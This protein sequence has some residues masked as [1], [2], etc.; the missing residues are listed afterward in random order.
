MTSADS[1]VPVYVSELS[2]NAV[3]SEHRPIQLSPSALQHVNLLVDELLTSIISSAASFNPKDIRLVG[4][5]AVFGGAGE[6]HA[7][8]QSTGPRALARA[9]VNEAEVELRSW[10]AGHPAPRGGRWPP[11]G[12]GRGLTLSKERS[13]AAFPMK[14]ALEYVRIHG[15]RFCTLAPDERPTEGDEDRVIRAHLIEHILAQ[16]GTVVQRDSSVSVATDQHLYTALCEDESVWGLFKRMK[17]KTTLEAAN[18]SAARQKK[19]PSGRSMNDL[20]SS[21]GRQSPSSAGE[22]KTSLVGAPREGSIDAGS[23]RRGAPP[24]S[25]FDA[26]RTSTEHGRFGGISGGPLRKA[27]SLSKKGIFGSPATGNGHERSNSVLSVNTRSMLGAYNEQVD[28]ESRPARSSREQEDDFDALLRSS[29]TMK[30]SLTPSRLKTFEATTRRGTNSPTS[31][32]FPHREASETSPQDELPPLLPGSN[33]P[34]TP[35]RNGSAR[36][37]RASPS[38]RLLAR[39]ASTIIAEQSDEDGPPGARSGKKESL[40]DILASDGPSEGNQRERAG[41]GSRRTVPAVV[42][43]TPPPPAPAP[44]PADR[45]APPRDSPPTLNRPQGRQAAAAVGDDDDFGPTRRRR[46]KSSAQ[47]LADFLNSTPP[48]P[49]PPSRPPASV[50]SEDTVATTKSKGLKGFM[51]KV[52]AG[53]SK[54]SSSS[55]KRKPAPLMEIPTADRDLV[56]AKRKQSLASSSSNPSSSLYRTSLEA[57]PVPNKAVQ[58]KSVLHKEPPETRKGTATP[59]S[60]AAA[61]AASATAAAATTAAV[62]IDRPTNGRL[63]TVEASASPPNKPAKSPGRGLP[64][65]LIKTQDEYVRPEAEVSGVHSV[66]ETIAAA[67]QDRQVRSLE[68]AIHSVPETAGA[69]NLA[70]AAASVSRHDVMPSDSASFQTADEDLSASTGD[71]SRVREAQSDAGVA[72]SEPT[73]QA[74]IRSAVGADVDELESETAPELDQALPVATESLVPSIPLEE[75]LPLRHLLEHATSARECQLLLGAVLTQWGVPLSYPVSISQPTPEDRVA[76]WLLAGR[77]GPVVSPS[78]STFSKAETDVMTPTETPTGTLKGVARMQYGNGHEAQDQDRDRE[79]EF[80]DEDEDDREEVLDE[81]GVEHVNKVAQV[82]PNMM[83]R[84]GAVD[85]PN[86]RDGVVQA[87]I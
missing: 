65:E 25:S 66:P 19:P 86:G 46:G 29:E 28:D 70:V 61:Y 3:I 26:S 84:E 6:K 50:A 57:P 5:P 24:P 9:A 14:E 20:K 60:A 13:G 10:Y 81:V 7:A 79:D 43:G 52:T 34:S 17:L 71:V 37:N 42:L 23:P 68:P 22:S 53:T 21:G 58:S 67:A 16:L 51:S 11:D 47:E 82:A 2:A 54:S 48:P 45:R 69:Q 75:L 83:G 30:V 63:S 39:G 4:V 64:T 62:V 41:S 44:A 77:E 73:V 76:A 40:M 80:E 74:A 33:L 18:E 12:E 35:P 55:S 32:A 31:S 87:G 36:G 49:V 78:G 8:G 56:A 27:A 85:V 59:Y 38:Q 15:P 72:G 1:I